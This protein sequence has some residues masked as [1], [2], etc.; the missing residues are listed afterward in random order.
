MPWS[1]PRLN[2][3]VSRNQRLPR[4]FQGFRPVAIL[5]VL[6]GLSSAPLIAM[7][8]L[9]GLAL[10]GHQRG[11]YRGV[12]LDRRLCAFLHRLAAIDA[13]VSGLAADVAP[14]G[15]G[16]SRRAGGR[17]SGMPAAGHHDHRPPQGRNP[18]GR[19]NARRRRWRA[20][21]GASATTCSRPTATYPQAHGRSGRLARPDAEGNRGEISPPCFADRRTLSDRDGAARRA[22]R[23]DHRG[24]VASVSTGDGPR[25]R[26]G[27]GRASSDFGASVAE[28]ERFCRESFPD[29]NTDD[30]RRWTA[31]DD[32]PAGDPLRRQPD[33]A[34]GDQG[35]SAR[36][37]AASPVA[38]RVSP[39]RWCCPI[40]GVR[41]CC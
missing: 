19:R 14:G 35:R 25:W 28:I 2:S 6:W 27:G 40:R 9:A 13:G 15:P 41:C 4:L 32:D 34:G 20:S 31:S 36:G 29:W 17:Q 8:G 37:P 33:Q 23:P 5:L 16:I 18:A 39:C 38:G 30:W 3:Q 11:L 22:P 10:G 21:S 26:S 1:R 12:F 7:F 24:D